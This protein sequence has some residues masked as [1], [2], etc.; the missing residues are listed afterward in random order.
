M[1]ETDYQPHPTQAHFQGSEDM[2][3]PQE[4]SGQEATQCLASKTSLGWINR[5]L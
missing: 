2:M 5:K 4:I 3:M 1:H